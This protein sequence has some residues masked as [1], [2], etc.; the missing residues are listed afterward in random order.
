M[1]F[2]EKSLEKFKLLLKWFTRFTR[3]IE[4]FKVLLV[5]SKQ[6]FTTFTTFMISV[7]QS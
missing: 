5:A 3:F 7:G 4:K 6:S 1:L 2:Y